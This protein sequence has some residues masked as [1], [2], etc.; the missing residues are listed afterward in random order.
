MVIVRILE[1]GRILAERTRFMFIRDIASSQEI[2]AGDHTLL[3]ELFN[4]LRDDLDLRY[5]LAVARIQPD[6][7]SFLHRLKNSEVY[8]FLKGSGVMRIDDETA[9]VQAGQVVYVPPGATQQVLNVSNEE[10]IFICIV[11]PAWKEDEE[12]ILGT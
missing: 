12:E 8:F 4:P 9:Q 11:D 1:V 2:V 3:K 6:G 10:L 5:S 7:L